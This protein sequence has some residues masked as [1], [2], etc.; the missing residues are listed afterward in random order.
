RGR[1]CACP[2]TPSTPR[3]QLERSSN[4]RERTAFPPGE[5]SNAA[6]D[7]RRTFSERPKTPRGICGPARSDMRANLDVAW[8]VRTRREQACGRPPAWR[9]ISIS[10]RLALRKAHHVA[11]TRFP[12]PETVPSFPVHL[13]RVPLRGGGHRSRSEARARCGP[14]DDQSTVAAV[15][16]WRR[17]HAEGSGGLRRWL[18]Q[19]R[20]R[21]DLPRAASPDGLCIHQRGHG[22][23]P[24]R[25]PALPTPSRV[26]GDA[27][28]E[29][30]PEGIVRRR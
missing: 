30:A 29:A 15:R 7:E 1:A 2:Y 14:V 24:E 11:S 18:R 27:P 5:S 26:G 3:L 21:L 25:G 16:A 8:P 13:A 22:L 17:G 10:T 28:P 12:V 20:S 6:F 4:G 9:S 19:P 23:G